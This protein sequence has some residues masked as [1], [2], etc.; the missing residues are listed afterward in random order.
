ML[1][2]IRRAVAALAL[3]PSLLAAQTRAADPARTDRRRDAAHPPGMSEIGIPVSGVRM[4]G[5]IYLAAGAGEH[6]V[7]VFLHG[8]PGNEKNLDLAQAVRRA[9][10]HAVYFDYRGTWGTGG[11]FA[12]AHGLEDADAALAWVRAPANVAKYHIDTRRIAV[13]GHSYGGWL[14]L[15][16]V[17]RQPAGVCVAAMA[18][19]NVGWAGARFGTVPAEEKDARDYFRATTDSVSGPIRGD[20]DAM[21]RE[22][23]EHGQAWNYVAQAPA[24]RDHTMLLIA[25]THDSPDEDVAMHTSLARALAAAGARRVRMLTYDDDHPF[26]AHR[27]A[28]ASDLI[29]WLRT[30]CAASQGAYS[31]R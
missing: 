8:Y 7:V 18:A 22:M 31:G 5:I 30:D 1:P 26:S 21:V 10:Y 9:G 14:A 17:G 15:M 23:S 25:A 28:L 20:A 19:W 16:T 24:L 11:T 6:P 2:T 12:F 13:V 27:I 3:A 29:R 4:N